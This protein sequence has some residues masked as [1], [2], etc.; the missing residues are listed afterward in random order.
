MRN[1]QSNVI[2]VL[3]N[4]IVEPSNVK[5]INKKKIKKPSNIIKVHSHVMLVLH[6]VTMKLLN[7]RK[8]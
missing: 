3:P 6:N 1:V 7:V 2:L 5:K 4:V 8:V